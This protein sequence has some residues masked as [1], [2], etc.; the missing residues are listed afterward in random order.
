MLTRAAVFLLLLPALAHGQGDHFLHDEAG[1]QSPQA[2][3]DG[4]ARVIVVGDVHGAHSALVEI[5]AA[6]GVID[7][8][9]HWTGGATHLVSLGDLLD[10]GPEARAALDLLMRLQDEATAQGGRVHVVLGN[11]E[12]M[13]LMGDLR[14]LT[15]PDYAAFAAEETET[16]RAAAYLSYA[17]RREV[18]DEAT[19]AL[20]DETYPRGYF[21]RQ[22]AMSADGTYGAWLL[23]LPAIVVI[24][25][26][27][28]VH[29]GLPPLV[30]E[31]SLEELN[32][33]V[34]TKLRRYLE[35]REELANAGVLPVGDM[36]RDRE[37]AQ[38]ALASANELAAGIREFLELGESP[39]L[40]SDGPLW[41]RGSVYCKPL[42]ERPILEA[43]LEQLAVAR[44]A[45]GHTPTSD[46][47]AH[48][49]YDGKL[50][51]LDTGMLAAY[52]NGRPT[53]LVIERE[54]VHV[55]Y[56][57]PVE[58]SALE[59][60]DTDEPYSFTEPELVTALE[61]ANIATVERTPDGAPWPVTLTIDGATV[62]AVFVPG[63]AGRAAGLEL[64]AAALDDL[65][66]TALVPPTVART[67]D[68]EEGALQ[69]RFP[70]AVTETQR[71]ARQLGFGWCPIDPQFDL[72]R[73]F[74]LLTYNRGRTGDNVIYRN[75]L[76]DLVLTD[77][78]N[79]FGTERALP[80]NIDLT[81]LAMPPAL[82]AELRKLDAPTLTKALG[83]SVDA[84]RVRALLARRDQLLENR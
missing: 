49:L 4:V 43:A 44:V 39:E 18:A 28:F 73:T 69:L 9:A 42:L 51:M 72:M 12:V 11:H 57:D 13:N 48:S 66:G 34:A 31:T 83:P 30:A 53:A 47:R 21:A 2:R 15:A 63:S 27:A 17:S 65:I 22:Q 64:A 7:A 62:N 55:Q 5:L 3:F 50:L 41:Y 19:L 25:D 26:T 60:G 56:A 71:A 58:R 45:V 61:Q 46:R 37:I 20:F 67:I 59:Q 14:Y 76:T 75:D 35:L 8:E 70:R 32:A 1:T 38:A 52:Y 84:R 79:A 78:R 82:V 23:S 74:D 16:L 33:A 80:S 10:R 54:Q 81:E 29:A 77:H 40:G 24:N 68:G 36:T 6:T